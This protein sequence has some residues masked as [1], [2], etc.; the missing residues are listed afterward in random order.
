MKRFAPFLVLAG[1]ALMG[2]WFLQ[3]GVARDENVYVQTRIFQEVVDLVAAQYVEEVPAEELY[4]SAIDGLLDELGD[5]HSAFI[6][7][8]D[9]EDFRIRTEGDYGG[10]GLE[11]VERDGRVTVVGPIPGTPGA[12]AG[13]RPGDWFVSVEGESVIGSDVDEVVDRLRGKPGEP[14]EVRMG[15]AGV[16]EPIPFTLLREVIRI[17]SVPFVEVLEGGVGY[18]PLQMFRSTST[19]EVRAAVDSLTAEGIR[20]LVLDLRGNPGGL[21]EEG[22]GITELFLDA[23]NTVVETRGRGRG[24]TERYASSRP[25]AFPRLPVAVL[26][27]GTSASASEIVAGAL[28]DHDRAVLVGMPTYGK[29]SVQTLFPVPAGARVRFTTALWYTPVGR[30]IDRELTGEV[31]FAEQAALGLDGTLVTPPD[32]AERPEFRSMDGRRLLG[33]GGI[34][35]DVVVVPDTLTAEE[36]RAVRA[37]YRQ[38]GAFT[39]NLF[40]FAV[41]YLQ[42]HPGLAEDFIVA[43]ALMDEFQGYLAEQGMDVSPEV[44]RDGS[45]YIRYQLEREIAL[46]AFGDAGEFLHARR[47][48]A[49]LRTALDLIRESRG[50]RQ[51][52]ARARDAASP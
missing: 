5:P 41:R 39:T 14:V 36:A 31:P 18:V 33:G 16:D 43:P 25:A 7:A 26:V 22:I 28:Q 42:E 40:N 52:I 34:V 6:E 44:F 9:Y 8:R 45:R 17:A 23:G 30:S 10:V 20:G 32:T 38:A 35:P 11:V 24:Q 47:S 13:I 51:L 46:Q 3:E 4:R 15:R 37:L 1:A 49:Q 27:D 2:G 48:D 19:E 29:G 21:L 50:T 12:R